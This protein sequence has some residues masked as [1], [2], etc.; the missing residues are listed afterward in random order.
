[1]GLRARK[2]S[3]EARLA[4]FSFRVNEEE[5]EMIREAAKD[6][7]SLNDFLREAVVEYARG[8]KC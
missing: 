3:C 7:E 6:R 1:M 5:E 2:G 4:V 8:S